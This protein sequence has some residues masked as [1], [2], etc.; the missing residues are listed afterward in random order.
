MK[1]FYV[2]EWYNKENGYIFYVGKGCR[3]RFR[4]TS[5]R[6]MLFKEY[7]KKNLCE[8]RIIKTFDNEQDAFIFEHEYIMELKAQKQAHCNLDFG[9]VGGCNFVWTLEMR[10][11]KSKYNPM[12][13][14]KQRKRMSD[15]NPMKNKETAE[16]VAKL[17][18]KP[19]IINGSF[20][21]SVKN[22]EKALGV[23]EG[24]IIKWCKRGWDTNGNPCRYAEE[25]QK[26]IPFFI[27]EHPKATTPK[28]VIVDGKFYY[29]VADAAKQIGVW[30]E[31]LI[32]AIKSNRKCKGHICSYANQQPS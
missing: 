20:F 10:E 22:A 32:R 19:V 28:A 8:C 23:T 27:K 1:M 12:K 3:N 2:Y 25:K 17:K 30:S 26:E 13:D 4:N 11:Y 24:A 31:S 18:R 9:G 14:A 6:N 21:E 15:K 29:T 16:S 7:I 5:Q